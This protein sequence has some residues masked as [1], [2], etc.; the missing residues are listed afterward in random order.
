MNAETQRAR[1]FSP[2]VNAHSALDG[3]RP[4]GSSL[5]PADGAWKVWLK[6][7]T[8]KPLNGD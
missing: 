3:P 4:E 7:N 1:N 8:V 5:D 6:T 2:N